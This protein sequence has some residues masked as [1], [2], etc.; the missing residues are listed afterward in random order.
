MKQNIRNFV[1]SSVVCL[2]FSSCA[3]STAV[4]KTTRP[5]W[6]NEPAQGYDTKAYVTAVGTGKTRSDAE[7]AA[8][9]AV[10]KFLRQNIESEETTSRSFS[11]ESEGLSTYM[12][13]VKA[14]TSIQNITGIDIK[15]NW[16]DPVDNTE[17]AYAVLD[18]HAAG[19]Y[20]F[21]RVNSLSSEIQALILEAKNNIGTFHGSESMIKAFRKATENE[22]YVDLASVIYP[23]YGKLINLPYGN[24]AEVA[25]LLEKQQKTV[26]V[27]VNVDGDKGGR[28]ANALSA[29]ISGMGIKT[30]SG[31]SGGADSTVPYTLLCTVTFQPVKL[32]DS[33]NSYVRYVLN[34]NLIETSSG[35]DFLPYSCNGR[36]GKL[37]QEEAEQSAIRTLEQKIAT[38]YGTAFT[39]MLNAQ[40]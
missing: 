12:S 25:S 27:M 16:T 19:K 13:N 5:A 33:A 36:V 37:S 15:S 32:A 18:R 10:G 7:N 4:K 2:L 30:V 34:A 40:Q 26:T 28:I 1:L 20:Y 29:A 38:E 39:T 22:Y 9:A 35:K 17:Y 6:I 14:E 8:A 11:S 31:S 3:T 21:D 24:V 23:A